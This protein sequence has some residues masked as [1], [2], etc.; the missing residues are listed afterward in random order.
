M[1]SASLCVIHAFN[2][3]I[4][5]AYY[6]PGTVSGFDDIAVN[7][8]EPFTLGKGTVY[9]LFD[10][11]ASLT[12]SPTRAGTLCDLLTTRFLVVRVCLVENRL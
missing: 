1:T 2:I 12:I 11:F 4:L 8:I 10:V 6:M 7:Q 3:N 5:N 9:N